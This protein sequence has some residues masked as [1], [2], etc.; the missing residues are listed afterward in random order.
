[1]T[2][3]LFHNAQVVL[4][5]DVMTGWVACQ[6]GRII[7]HGT[8]NP[9]ESGGHDC[10]G[11]YLI[12][13]L[14]EL[15]SDHLEA[16]VVPRPKVRWHELA[17][18]LAYDAQMAASGIT[19]IFDSLR[20]GSDIDSRSLGAEVAGLATTIAAAQRDGLLRADHH[21]HLR[22]EVCTHDVLE[23]AQELVAAH[24]VGM[25]S[26]MDHT[27]GSRQ[28]RSVETWKTYYGGKS[29]L[30]SAALDVLVDE[31][32]TLHAANHDH[33]RAVLVALARANGVV[34]AS[35]D[36][37]TIPHVELSVADGV[38][39]AEFPTTIEAAAASH[40]AGIQVLMG[41]PNVVRGGS[42]SGNVSAELLA[43]E[44]LLD[45]LSSDYVPSSLLIG[46]FD[47][48]RRVETLSLADAIRMVSLNPAQATGLEDRGVIEAGFKADVIR[49]RLHGSDQLPVVREVYRDGIRI[50]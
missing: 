30:S 32:R 28:F 24:K 44:G 17:A 42:H 21:M 1:M 47:L 43:R 14:V 12:P 49:V 16:H 38:S 6:G 15:H 29:G 31:R 34:L 11:D 26:L 46:A 50:I 20:V 3:T 48:A 8:G 39:M 7:E 13:G 18:V 35:H 4:R 36:D 45:L 33:H 5:D 27:P 41:A 22:C 25:I 40:A 2:V 37:T 23:A 10:G 9:P 19:T